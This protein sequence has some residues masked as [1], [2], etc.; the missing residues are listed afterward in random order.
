[1]KPVRRGI[2]MVI[3]IAVTAV[4]ALQLYYLIQIALWSYFNPSST[5]FMREQL[6]ILQAENPKAQLQFE[7]VDYDKIS[8]QL[9][10][11]VIAAED[12][13]F[14]AHDGIEWDA[15]QDAYLKN[16]KKGKVVRGGST[17]T[18]Q[19]AKNLFLSGERSYIRKGQEAIIATMLE[20]ILDKRR[21]LEL[22]LN[23]AEWG[24]GVFGASMRP[25]WALHRPLN[26]HR[27]CPG[28]VTMTNIE[29]HRT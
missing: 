16:Q 3:L 25:I 23:V 19:L 17:I 28:R 8:N 24:Q 11:A 13:G 1:M 26:W 20:L 12:A 6:A 2:V 21:I 15:I 27:C 10:R 5:S 14:N 4:I 18:Q 9:K 29:I 22:Y 7:W